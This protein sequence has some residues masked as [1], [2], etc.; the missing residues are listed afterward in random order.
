[1]GRGTSSRG[2]SRLGKDPRDVQPPARPGK[3]PW[4]GWVGLPWAATLE[5]RRQGAFVCRPIRM[6]LSEPEGADHS[7]D[8]LARAR[9]SGRHRRYSWPSPPCASGRGEGGARR[10]P[11]GMGACCVGTDATQTSPVSSPIWP[12]RRGV[13]QCVPPT[14]PG[15]GGVSI[16]PAWIRGLERSKTGP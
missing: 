15:W 6:W 8:D 12:R 10:Y 4:P 13:S 16:R 7:C 9:R 5:T 2:A 11:V 3:S 1:M 14:K